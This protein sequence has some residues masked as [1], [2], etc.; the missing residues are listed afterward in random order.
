MNVVYVTELYITLSIVIFGILKTSVHDLVGISSQVGSCIVDLE[1]CTLMK[2]M[3]G[4]V[5]NLS[6]EKLVI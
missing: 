3:W 2:E 4:H 1:L 5:C 6:E